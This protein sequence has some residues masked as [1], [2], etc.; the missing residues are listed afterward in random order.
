MRGAQRGSSMLNETG[1]VRINYPYTKSQHPRAYEMS[2]LESNMEGTSIMIA[3]TKR[4][5]SIRL[6]VN[7][8]S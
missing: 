4:L 1:A 7:P 5:G 3:N 8:S 6:R 2:K